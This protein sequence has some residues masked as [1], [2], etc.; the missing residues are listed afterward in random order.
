MLTVDQLQNLR[1]GQLKTAVQDWKHMVGKLKEL[2]DGGGGK[3]GVTAA[4][5]KSRTEAAN[6]NGVNATVGREFVT[7]TAKQFDDAV[8]EAEGVHALLSDAHTRFTQHKTDLND[9][10]TDLMKQDISVNAKGRAYSSAPSGAAAG[11]VKPPTEAELNA[12]QSRIDKIM[13]AAD[14]DDRVIARALRDYAKNK[15]DFSDQAVKGADDAEKQQGKKDAEY[16]ANKI[17]KGDVAHW[18][19]ADVARFNKVL[20]EQKDNPAFAE[21]FAT[22]LGADGTLQ[23]WR[24]L[25]APPGGA[26]DGERAKILAHVQ[27]NLSMTLATATHSHS[28]AMEQW[29]HDVIAAGDKVFPVDPRMPAGPKGFQVMS[30]LMGK[31]TFDGKFLDDYGKSLLTYERG[32]NGDPDAFWGLGAANL[33]YPPTDHIND[34]V[35]GFLD[36]LSHN[37]KESVAF[38][39]E[40]SGEGDDKMSNF[41]YLLGDG[42]DAREWP[43]DDDGHKWGQ[44]SLGHALEAATEGVPYGSDATHPPHSQDSADLVHRLVEQFGNHPDTLDDSE[45][46]PS[47]GHITA[48]YMRDVQGGINGD[49]G[50]DIKTYGADA[51]LGDIDGNA[52][53]R[54]LGSVGKD[55]DAYGSIINAQQAVTTE[56][57]DDAFRDGDLDDISLEVNNRV[58][59]GAKIAGVMAESRTHAI[60]DDKIA[61][62]EQFNDGVAKADEVAGKLI[63]YGVSQ[64]PVG[65]DVASE[66]IG[67]VREAVVDH[68]TVD[69]SAEYHMERGDFLENQQRSSADAVHDAVYTAA[70]DAGEDPKNA[71]SKAVAA[72]GQVRDTYNQ[73]RQSEE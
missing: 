58:E 41:D 53:N 45:L 52:L 47:F 71:E 69:H 34:P 20:A 61:S 49:G 57:V 63:D 11:D 14:E 35:T 44:K 6:W 46:R 31:G 10:I 15:Y 9:A 68:Y 65:G 1:L 60:Y 12:A 18:S 40:S 32:I 51:N 2:N 56:L 54:F 39:D 4:G 37:P 13:D 23:F 8:V 55:P 25:A 19:D 43:Q 42:D 70:I 72:A 48:D 7:K 73:G 33:D 29:K 30:S 36:G 22:R 38:F 28:P 24:D 50:V 67:K 62:D 21:T 17:K 64:I 5:L 66:V 27:D 26:V 16:W 59:P 3:G